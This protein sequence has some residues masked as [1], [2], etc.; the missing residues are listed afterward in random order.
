[1]TNKL[2]L[3]IITDINAYYAWQDVIVNK[4]LDESN[5]EISLHLTYKDVKSTSK[6][7]PFFWKL[8][9]GIDSKIF[10]PHPFALHN[11]SNTKFQQGEF[12]TKHIKNDERFDISSYKIDIILNFSQISRPN[13]NLN[14]VTKGMWFITP[15]D[16]NEVNKRPYGIWELINKRSESVAVLRR[17]KEDEISP[18]T[19]AVTSSCSDLLSYKRNINSLMWQ[20]SL[21]FFHNIKLLADNESLFNKKV[22]VNNSIYSEKAIEPDE[23]FPSNS[24]IISYTLKLYYNK[25][26]QLI[27]SKFYF[28]QWALIY[29]NN[30]DR[31]LP[32]DFS[33]YKLIL[34]PKDRFWADP[35]L[36]RQNG[37]FYLFIE[38]L[39]YK[40]K[41]GHLSVMEID[42]N[43]NYSVPEKIMVKDYHLSY[44]FVFEDQGELYMIPETSGNKD[45][46][47][48]KCVDFPLKWELEKV[49][50]DNVIAV[51]TTI[52]KLNET[53]WMFTNLKKHKGAVKHVELYAF[54]TDNLVSGQWIEH[55][56]NPVVTDIKTSR[57][58][59]CIFQKNNKLYRPSQDCSHFYG[60]GLNIMEITQLTNSEY[61]EK[62]HHKIEPKWNKSI[63]STHTYN[64][65]DNMEIGDVKIRR[66]RFF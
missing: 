52:H 32:F 16:L 25:I 40:N 65:A 50:M 23:I 11:V 58:A 47:L 20:A 64:S 53:Y 54:S 24:L 51:D 1:M 28:N 5:I 8:F 15:C 17:L 34:P 12:E 33:N 31:N 18:S 14:Q 60:Y 21:L 57:P 13:I 38:E 36:L 61:E 6:N 62:L 59:G 56:L 43:G 44:P 22:L 48:Y 63:I 30:K 46:Q 10:N 29:R 66:R 19:I 39:I 49:L 4:L 27:N 9:K 37:K 26:K 42:E 7:I 2:R 41:L 35:F 45:I 3:A 55:P